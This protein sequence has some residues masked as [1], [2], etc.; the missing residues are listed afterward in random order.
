MASALFFGLFLPILI[1]ID[2]R[3][4][5]KTEMKQLFF[6]PQDGGVYVTTAASTYTTM[7][8]SPRPI[9]FDFK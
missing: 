7:V 6:N 5:I 4:Q 2:L 8:P 3:S 9:R 1:M